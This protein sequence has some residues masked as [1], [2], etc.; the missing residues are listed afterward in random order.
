VR[1]LCS[2]REVMAFLFGAHLDMTDGITGVEQGIELRGMVARPSTNRLARRPAAHRFRL[3]IPQARAVELEDGAGV[4]VVGKVV[5]DGQAQTLTVSGPLPVVIRVF[6]AAD[7]FD[8]TVEDK[9]AGRWH[10]LI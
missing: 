3:L 5:H 10:D 7:E 4:M 6:T 9:P 2:D 1:G 8:L